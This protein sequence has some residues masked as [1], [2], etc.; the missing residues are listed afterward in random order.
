MWSSFTYVVTALG[1]VSFS[2]LV[3]RRSVRV[4][5]VRFWILVVLATYSP[6]SWYH[7]T[8]DCR[9]DVHCRCT[10]DLEVQL[11]QEHFL[12]LCICVSWRTHLA[13]AAVSVA[14]DV[15]YVYFF[16]YG[17]FCRRYWSC[18]LLLCTSSVTNSL[19]LP[20]HLVLLRQLGFVFWI[21][22]VGQVRV[23]TLCFVYVR[24]CRS[25]SWSEKEARQKERGSSS[26]TY[27]SF[28]FVKVSLMVGALVH[29]CWQSH[30][31]ATIVLQG[32]GVKETVDVRGRPGSGGNYG[33]GGGRGGGAG[34]GNSLP[35]HSS[36]GTRLL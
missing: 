31:D 28:T 12:V 17:A 21:I 11:Y 4:C 10:I 14:T 36:V 25:L 35:R 7:P 30:W 2:M 26:V 20:C 24:L 29:V 18:T 1:D 23:L 33:R 9:L 15:D 13:A 27:A 8:E 22:F 32:G 3:S 34:R 19:D 16:L 6:W 5:T